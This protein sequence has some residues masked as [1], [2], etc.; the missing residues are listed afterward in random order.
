MGS[1]CAAHCFQIHQ[2]G[3]ISRE[4]FLALVALFPDKELRGV[5]NF[6]LQ[7]LLRLEFFSGIIL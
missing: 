3:V 4:E 1:G 6:D 7:Y 2:D 5:Y